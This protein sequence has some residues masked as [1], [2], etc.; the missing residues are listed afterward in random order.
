MHNIFFTFDGEFKAAFGDISDLFVHVTVHRARAALVE[1]DFHHHLR[2]AV[3][4][5]LAAGFFVQNGIGNGFIF[6][7]H[8]FPP[9][10]NAMCKTGTPQ[11]ETCR[12][13]TSVFVA[14]L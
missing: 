4:K 10:K 9:V 8:N 14:Y 3:A 13:V 7:N 11:K 1:C 5:D 6:N 2:A 12:V